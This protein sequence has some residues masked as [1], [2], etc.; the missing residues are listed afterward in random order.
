MES[1]NINRHRSE[2]FKI[3]SLLIKKI[4]RVRA[5]SH[6]SYESLIQLRHPR[7]VTYKLNRY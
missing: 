5:K 2:S 6:D 1:S 3:Q 4:K 7:I